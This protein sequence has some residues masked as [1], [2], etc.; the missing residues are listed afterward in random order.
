MGLRAY[1]RIPLPP[2]KAKKTKGIA[3]SKFTEKPKTSGE[4]CKSIDLQGFVFLHPSLHYF[5]YGKKVLWHNH[6]ASFLK[7]PSILL[8]KAKAAL[9][10]ILIEIKNIPIF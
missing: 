5:Q 10:N 1:V 8:Q 9:N 2:L 4:P 6:I 7:F 3:D